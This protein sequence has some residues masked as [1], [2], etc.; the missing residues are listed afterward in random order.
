MYMGASS[1]LCRVTCRV[2][3]PAF[4]ACQLQSLHPDFA[5]LGLLQAQWALPDASPGVWRARPSDSCRLSC[6]ILR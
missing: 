1:S 5:S 2:L 3:H 6:P 4:P